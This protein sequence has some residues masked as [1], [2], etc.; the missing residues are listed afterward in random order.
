MKDLA[1]KVAWILPFAYWFLGQHAMETSLVMMEVTPKLGVFVWFGGAIVTII[2][3]IVAV[4]VIALYGL[5]FLIRRE[6]SGGGT[7]RTE[8]Q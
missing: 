5:E 3:P 6:E 1:L 7:S 4:V 8:E 2:S